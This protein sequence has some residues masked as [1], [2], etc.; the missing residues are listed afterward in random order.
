[1]VPSETV[2]GLLVYVAEEEFAAYEA[3]FGHMSSVLRKGAPGASGNVLK[4][5]YDVFATV[6]AGVLLI[7][8]FDNLLR[9]VFCI[10]TSTFRQ[11]FMQERHHSSQSWMTTLFSRG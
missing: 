3:V 4:A 6:P 11:A 1:M 8:A 2:A 10:A 7:L 9:Q 5:C